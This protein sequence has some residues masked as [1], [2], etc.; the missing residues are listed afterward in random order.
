MEGRKDVICMPNIIVDDGTTPSVGPCFNCCEVA[1]EPFPR[2][3]CRIS[4]D[5]EFE[6]RKL[7]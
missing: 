1:D 7:S 4:V 6:I 5:E 2:C 3:Q